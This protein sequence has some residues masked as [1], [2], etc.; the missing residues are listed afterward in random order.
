LRQNFG[1]AS[2]LSEQGA[3]RVAVNVAIALVVLVIGFFVARSVPSPF[4]R[5]FIAEHGNTFQILNGSP[6]TSLPI[7]PYLNCS[8]MSE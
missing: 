8:L 3:T 1:H 6:F 4:A 2:T 7:E 5:Q